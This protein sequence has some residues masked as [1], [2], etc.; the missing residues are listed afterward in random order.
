MQLSVLPK[1]YSIHQF[2]PGVLPNLP[3]HGFRALLCAEDEVTL[4]C[5]SHHPVQSAR[6]ESGWR[7]IKIEAIMEFSMVGVVA[8]ISAILAAAEI[9]IF[10]L[11]TFNTDYILVKEHALENALNA[12][13][14]AGYTLI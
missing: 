2:L 11:S 7:A 6:S 1:A 9:S 4:V 13:T 8:R 5:E 10:V 3:S 12:L 14:T